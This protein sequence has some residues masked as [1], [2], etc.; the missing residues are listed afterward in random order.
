MFLLSA[1]VIDAERVGIAVG[2]DE[3][4]ELH[5]RR[6]WFGVALPEHFRRAA[7]QLH[8]PVRRVARCSN[9]VL[10][11][12]EKALKHR[13]PFDERGAAAALKRHST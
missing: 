9:G 6:T 4:G 13:S 1:D 11:R 8:D 12:R 3:L 5:R 10:V 2:H 7:R